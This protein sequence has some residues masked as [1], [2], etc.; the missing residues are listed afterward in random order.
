MKKLKRLAAPFAVLA[1]IAPA[2]AQFAPPKARAAGAGAANV[3]APLS[4]ASV[5]LQTSWAISA[6]RPE[7]RGVTAFAQRAIVSYSSN[8]SVA[9]GYGRD[10]TADDCESSIRA[11]ERE[12][13]LPPYLLSAIA[14]AESG[15]NGRP[16]PVAMNIGGRPYF[17]SGTQDM[18]AVVERFGGER[19][20]IDVGCMQINLRFHAG[21]FKDWRSLLVPKYNAQYAALYLTELY[22]VYRSWDRA[23]GAYHSRTPWKSADYACLISRRWGQIFGS[24]RSGCGPD[25]EAMAQLMYRTYSNS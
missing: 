12:Y 20:S 22:R 8:A 10:W 6:A 16:S 11:A 25:I 5:P 19:A 15:R 14:L 4:R 23:V 1:F 24:T 21:R 13:H 9:V 18:Q 17:A 7:A 2:T 3:I